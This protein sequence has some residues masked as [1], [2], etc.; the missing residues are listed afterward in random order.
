MT[1]PIYA[2][3]KRDEAEPAVVRA[4]ENGGA[5]VAKLSA[6]DL[7]D[8]L[9][10]FLGVTHLVEVKTNRARM[11]NGQ[12]TFAKKWLGSPVVVARTAAQARKWL[13]VWR[14]RPTLGDVLRAQQETRGGGVDQAPEDA[15]HLAA[16]RARLG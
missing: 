13:A 12:E 2:T 14:E 1:G 10:G 7:P 5:M 8:L 6:R 15:D 3:G 9:V 11:R 4:F 16:E